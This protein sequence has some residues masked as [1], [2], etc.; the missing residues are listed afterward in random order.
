MRTV[1]VTDLGKPVP[2]INEL[3]YI[4]GDIYA[5][6]WFSNRIARISPESGRVLGWIDLSGIIPVVEI[7]SS[8]SVLNGIAWDAKENRIFVTGK[9]WPKLFEIRVTHEAH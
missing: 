4:H 1:T 2:E 6:I 8:G 3:E 5:N 7:L 9:Q